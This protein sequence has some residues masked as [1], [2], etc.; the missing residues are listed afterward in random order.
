MN[1]YPNK[2]NNI[3]Y[4]RMFS[5]LTLTFL[6]I[7]LFIVLYGIDY[8]AIGLKKIKD[9]W[10][11]YKCNPMVMPFAGTLGY[12]TNANFINCVGDIQGI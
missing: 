9:E 11:K 4:Y 8:F 7:I 6:I 12:D 2:N 3:V 1:F 5:D 10:P